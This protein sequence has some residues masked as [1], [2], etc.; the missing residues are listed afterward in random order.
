[1]ILKIVDSKGTVLGA[2]NVYENNC[3]GEVFINDT[4]HCEAKV[5]DLDTI[6]GTNDSEVVVC[7]DKEVIKNVWK[8]FLE[9]NLEIQKEFDPLSWVDVTYYDDGTG[10]I[11]FADT[12]EE[13]DQDEFFYKM[14]KI[15][16][17]INGYG[18]EAELK[19][20]PADRD[21]PYDEVTILIDFG[22]I[23]MKNLV[24]DAIV[25]FKMVGESD[26]LSNKGFDTAEIMTV[27]YC[28]K[29][30][31]FC[32]KYGIECDDSMPY[33]ILDAEYEL[34]KFFKAEL[35]GDD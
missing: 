35:K 1:M 26:G 21:C 22:E 14:E 4:F 5:D 3:N 7:I 31:D 15:T 9:L 12:G 8:L 20:F 27:D 32:K 29:I 19:K 16:S 17:F 11:S 13:K 6:F 28:D 10:T 33:G 34:E 30:I 24:V 25:F 23:N 18:Y 2:V